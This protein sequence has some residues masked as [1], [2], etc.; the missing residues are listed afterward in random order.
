MITTA[1]CAHLTR[2][3]TPTALALHVVRADIVL[4]H[5][6]LLN[7][8]HLQLLGVLR[9]GYGQLGRVV[10]SQSG[11]WLSEL[12]GSVG[13][14]SNRQTAS[15]CWR[16]LEERIGSAG[17]GRGRKQARAQCNR[18]VG[19]PASRENAVRYKEASRMHTVLHTRLGVR[20]RITLLQLHIPGQTQ[21]MQTRNVQT[22]Q[23]GQLHTN[24]NQS[25][26]FAH[27]GDEYQKVV[28]FTCLLKSPK[29]GTSPA[30]GL[31]K[32]LEIELK[33]VCKRRKKK[34]DESKANGEYNYM[35]YVYERN[36]TT[37]VKWK[38]GEG[39]DD[40]RMGPLRR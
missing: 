3:A 11:S 26:A 14:C 21:E 19:R 1:L 20:W 34:Q 30:E 23:G 27:E 16:C 2:T 38:H 33:E 6:L 10:C 24:T 22:L 25:C 9:G 5:L 37:G 17:K 18:G 28:P 35:F 32:E 15:C 40:N 7:V 39:D 12:E 29:P 8:T 13:R 31:E 4:R 36:F